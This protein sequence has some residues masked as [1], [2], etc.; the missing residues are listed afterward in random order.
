MTD[1]MIAREHSKAD[2]DVAPESFE[3]CDDDAGAKFCDDS[4]VSKLNAARKRPE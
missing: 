4:A 2:A 3:F 1:F